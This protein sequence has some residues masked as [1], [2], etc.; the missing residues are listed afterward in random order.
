LYTILAGKANPAASLHSFEPLEP[1]FNRLKKNVEINSIESKLHMIALGDQ[2]GAS[3]IYFV[4]TISGTF[5]QASLNKGHF[6]GRPTIKLPINVDTLAA[7]IQSGEIPEIDLMKIDV[8]TF[9]PFVLQG[10]GKYL[11]I[12]R[13]TILLE[14]LNNKVARDVFALTQNLKYHLYSIDEKEGVVEINS[15]DATQFKGNYL[16]LNKDKHKMDPNCF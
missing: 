16:L 7:E 13:P 12:F 4:K 9:E 10:L 6:K 8:E 2:K 5:D 14:I 3:S 1:V 15:L 11:A